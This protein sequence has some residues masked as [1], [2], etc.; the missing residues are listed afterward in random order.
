VRD[1]PGYI[2]AEPD[3]TLIPAVVES[4]GADKLFYASDQSHWDNE[5]P[6]S[7]DELLSRSD[8][9][10]DD[11]LKLIARDNALALYR[12]ADADRSGDS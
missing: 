2:H 11:D 1:A 7:L 12:M 5:Y 4:V 9:S 6:H 3:E 10:A 8:L